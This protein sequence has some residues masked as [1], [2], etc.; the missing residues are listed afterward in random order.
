MYLTYVHLVGIKRK[1][2][3]QEC[4]E[5]KASKYKHLHPWIGPAGHWVAVTYTKK[6]MLIALCNNL[7]SQYNQ[8]GR[9]TIR[10]D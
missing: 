1:N 10:T 2:W 3:M 6:Q 7:G 8:H 9:A 5:L 4:T